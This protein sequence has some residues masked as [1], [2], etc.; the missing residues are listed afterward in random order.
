MCATYQLSFDDLAE[1]KEISD[2]ITNK[3]GEDA[4][5]RAFSGDFFP[6]SEAPVIGKRNQIIMLKWG[7]P[8]KNSKRVIF[9]ARAES[10]TEKPLYRGIISNRCL[11]PATAFYE[12]D[13]SK[14]KYRI[15]VDGARLFYMAALWKAE[16]I[17][18]NTKVYYYTIITTEPNRQIKEIHSRMPAIIAPENSK[19][20]LRDNKKALSLL[21][22]FETEMTLTAV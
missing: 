10:L 4:A 15:S 19:A 5:N 6:K 22:P 2:E 1:I 20:W 18:D 12:W 14:T 7:F 9:N 16:T 13:S 21:R 17:N 11:V 3:Y 8:M